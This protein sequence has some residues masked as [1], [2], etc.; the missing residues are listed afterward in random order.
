M[1]VGAL[2]GR[3]VSRIHA[4]VAFVMSVKISANTNDVLWAARVERKIKTDVG[5]EVIKALLSVEGG[6]RQREGEDASVFDSEGQGS[7]DVPDGGPRHSSEAGSMRP[8]LSPFR[9]ATVGWGLPRVHPD[10][11]D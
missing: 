10:G 1:P 8:A 6:S 7:T 5:D 3:G 4:D 9:E 11:H 2:E